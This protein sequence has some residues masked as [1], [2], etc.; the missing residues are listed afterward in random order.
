ML[1][2]TKRELNQQTAKILERVTLEGEVIVS[3][4]GE[5]KW[6]IVRYAK[7]HTLEERLDE[8]ERQGVAIQRP[9]GERMKFPKLTEKQYTEA[10]MEALIQEMKGD[11]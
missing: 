8:L 1:T 9:K 7:A 10:E 11:R 3:E 5:P 4:Y 2:I 6:K